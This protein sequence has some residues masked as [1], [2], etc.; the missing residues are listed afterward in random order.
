MSD[1]PH[2][3]ASSTFVDPLRTAALLPWAP[4]ALTVEEG[5]VRGDILQRSEAMAHSEM[6]ACPVPDVTKAN[7]TVA[8]DIEA[9]RYGSL[10]GAVMREPIKSHDE[11]GGRCF[12]LQLTEVLISPSPGTK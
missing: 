9:C 6:S 8:G 11:R 3:V 2:D 10:E 7:H 4:W 1:A 12:V 5:I